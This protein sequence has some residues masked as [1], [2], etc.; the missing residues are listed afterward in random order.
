MDNPDWLWKTMWD[1]PPCEARS[2]VVVDR[3]EAK[4]SLP[5]VGVA[6][7]VRRAPPTA[8]PHEIRKCF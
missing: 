6:K 3:G 2:V 5:A 1:F 8:L 7:G 4:G